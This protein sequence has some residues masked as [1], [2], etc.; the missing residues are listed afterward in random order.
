[1]KGGE[2]EGLLERGGIAG[3]Q[4]NL[5]VKDDSL[6][7]VKANP[8]PN[9]NARKMKATAALHEDRGVRPRRDAE[10]PAGR[11]LSV[12]VINKKERGIST[13]YD[14]PVL[15]FGNGKPTYVGR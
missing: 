15:F 7:R 8:S 12:K 14:I 2:G 13:R 9:Q 3:A 10:P 4:T 11:P 5:H 6:V 1:M